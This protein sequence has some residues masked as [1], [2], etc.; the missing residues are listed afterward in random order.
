MI[1]AIVIDV[2]YA[3]RILRRDPVF[4]AVSTLAI[5]VAIGINSTL[6]SITNALVL[7]PLPYR[8]SERLVMIWATEAKQSTLRMWAPDD[9]AAWRLQRDIFD[10]TGA[11]GG[12]QGALTI[13]GERERA[14]TWRVSP[15]LFPL[16][17][18]KPALGRTFLPGE[19]ENGHQHV[20]V[21]SH[22]L[23]AL[24][25]QSDPTIVGKSVIV[26]D[27]A[28]IVV[29]VM[30]KGFN[31]PGDA[32]LWLPLVLESPAAVRGYSLRVLGRLRA[33]LSLP[34]AQEQANT[35][36]RAATPEGLRGAKL[37]ALQEQIVGKARPGLVLLSATAGIVLLIACVTVA[38]LLLVRA[39]AREDEIAIRHALGAAHGVSRVRSWPRVS[40]CSASVGCLAYCSASAPATCCSVRSQA[41]WREFARLASRPTPRYSPLSRRS[42]RACS[43]VSRR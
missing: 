42:R 36:F 14:E 16:L 9:L 21:L 3:L 22:R 25:F 40:C 35:V 11:Y 13:R 41:M 5:G 1:N 10:E 33:G 8:E 38:N 39:T 37:V 29:G 27:T 15:S 18:V 26:N 31:F 2:R 28:S 34:A 23:W 4:A 32:D 43:Q 24:R 7:N 19:D 30:P 6:F 12:L 17:G 20:V